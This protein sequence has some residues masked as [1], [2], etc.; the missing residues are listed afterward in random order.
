MDFR[1]DDGSSMS[2]AEVED[3]RA[4]GDVYFCDE[5]VEHVEGAFCPKHDDGPCNACGTMLAK[6]AGIGAPDDIQCRRC[7]LDGIAIDVFNG[8]HP[9]RLDPDRTLR[10]REMRLLLMAP[11]ILRRAVRW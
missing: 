11:G 10:H 5:C 2:L 8:W 6:G 4:S 9:V 3:L 1:H 7:W